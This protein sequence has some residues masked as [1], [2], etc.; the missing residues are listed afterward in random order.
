MF[1][2]GGLLAI[3]CSHS[4]DLLEPL[5]GASGATSTGG[6]GGEA[7]GSTSSAG[8]AGG[9]TSSSTS[10]SSSSS[11]STGGGVLTAYYKATYAACNSET[12]LAPAECE[13]I[14]G[15]GTMDVDAMTPSN[16]VTRGFVRFDLDSTLVGKTVDSV[17][18][19]LTTLNRGGANSDKSGDIWQVTPFTLASL[20]MAQP[21]SIG[22]VLA[23]DLGPV[24]LATDCFWVLPKGVVAPNAPVFLGIDTGSVD[25]VRYWNDHGAVPPLLTVQYH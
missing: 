21:T 23:A 19:R 13:K 20:A 8:G 6:A 9:A 3:G 16:W 18:L 22:P 2:L 7:T 11:A 4:W 5:G 15:A 24:E 17:T 1:L 12:N 25:G 14:S 10:A